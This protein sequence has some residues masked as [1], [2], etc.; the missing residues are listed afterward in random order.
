MMMEGL[1]KCEARNIGTRKDSLQKLHQQG[2]RFEIM[3]EEE[4]CSP[5]WVTVLK[6]C[7]DE[8]PAERPSAEALLVEI[9]TIIEA[10]DASRVLRRSETV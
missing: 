10:A 5:A 9:N 4:A 8:V 3:E 1:L 6:R 7:W 2:K